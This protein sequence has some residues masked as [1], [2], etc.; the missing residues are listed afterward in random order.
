MRQGLRLSILGCST[1][2]ASITA[3]ATARLET[4]TR[5]LTATSNA[6]TATGRTTTGVWTVEAGAEAAFLHFDFDTIDRMRVVVDRVL[7]SS[8]RLKINEG[9]IL[10]Y[11]LA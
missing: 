1:A 4:A 5:S 10:H 8:G 2:A 3:T 9:T 7:K 6:S 11:V